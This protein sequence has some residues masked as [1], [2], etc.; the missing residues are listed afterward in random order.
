MESV[1]PLAMELSISNEVT[2]IK[3]PWRCKINVEDHNLHLM[4]LQ[5]VL[6][7]CRSNTKS[8]SNWI[9][10]KEKTEYAVPRTWI[11]FKNKEPAPLKPNDKWD[12]RNS[13]KIEVLGFI[14]GIENVRTG[15][16][17]DTQVAGF[18]GESFFGEAGGG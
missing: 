7:R 8:S 9:I 18:C 5:K 10:K 3:E 12:F 14:K 13:S 15:S 17:I 6:C 11:R 16:G 1:A 2:F 4:H